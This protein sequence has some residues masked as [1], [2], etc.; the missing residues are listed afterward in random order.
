MPRLF[1][2]VLAAMTASISA[3]A[4]ASESEQDGGNPDVI[5]EDELTAVPELNAL[6]AIQRLR[7]GWLRV[8]GAASFS[9]PQGIRVYV[10]GMARGGVEELRALRATNIESMRFLSGRDAT[11]RFGVDHTN[12]AIMVRLRR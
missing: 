5:L 8:R 6:E 7:S 11:T 9:R 3:C 12:G 2:A 4:T 1:I 10:N